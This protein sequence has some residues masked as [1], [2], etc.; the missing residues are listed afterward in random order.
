MTGNPS[1]VFFRWD[2]DFRVADHSLR[3]T[4]TLRSVFRNAEL[5]NMANPDKSNG[6]EE[7]ASAFLAVFIRNQ[8]SQ[9]G[10]AVLSP[11]Q[12]RKLAADYLP[13]LSEDG[14]VFTF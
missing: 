2:L 4:I 9:L 10:G 3:A 8:Q 13:Q 6:Y 14:L 7:V 11:K 5:P 12:L 1:I